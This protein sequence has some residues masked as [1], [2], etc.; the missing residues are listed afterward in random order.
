MGIK[1]S[2]NFTQTLYSIA[3]SKIFAVLFFAVTLLIG[4]TLYNDYGI[5][6]DEPVQRELGNA[7]WNY[8]L[9]N[10]DSL[11]NLINRF[12]GPFIEMVE[13]LPER[14]LKLTDLKEIYLWRH[15]I[16]YFIF[17]VGSIF[18][19]LL[20]FKLFKSN[21]YAFLSVIILYLTPRIFAHSFYNSKD[22][23][24]M[25]FFIVNVYV[26]IL[27]IEK[28]S[29]K[30]A[31]VF[32]LVT[33][34]AFSIRILG[35]LIPAIAFVIFLI[36]LVNGKCKTQQLKYLLCYL[37]LFPIA[38]YVF[39]PVLWANPIDGLN[40]AFSIM[41]HYPY[42]DP[43]LFMGQLIAPQQLP[44]YY[45]P[46]WMAITIP[47]G[48]QIFFVIG[49]FSL[50]TLILKDSAS[51]FKTQINWIIIL[52]WLLVPYI[53]ILVLKS[54]VYDEWRHLFFIYPAFILIAVAAFKFLWER[55]FSFQSKKIGI[56]FGGFV[57]LMII[58]QIIGVLSFQI[59]NHPFENVYFNSIASKNVEQKF[60][61]DYWGLSYRQA[62]AQLVKEN[63]DETIKLC[64]QNSPGGYNL[65][66]LSQ[67]DGQRIKEVS[68]DSAAYFITNYRFHPEL[69]NKKNIENFYSI[70]V[71][72]NKILTVFKK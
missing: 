61:L 1:D 65:I 2:M 11:F 60:D 27:F 28:P 42:D 56:A 55:S 53:M 66:W 41:S 68:W 71:E 31:S 21:R 62:L 6:W 52:A 20:A 72:G 8:A 15:A 49:F 33:G 34:M 54:S 35:I 51:F 70:E 38:S 23:P 47:I 29:F 46:V 4:I 24:L 12:H 14:V 19:F 32:S 26:L 3:R 37:I 63:K 9:H 30:L 64:W 10:D 57:S 5:S 44:W 16:N 69:F 67:S 18:L 25:I 7:S 36:C 43:Q 48:W 39:Y 50:T 17:W 59:K 13:Q 45:I 40:S 58:I 22:I